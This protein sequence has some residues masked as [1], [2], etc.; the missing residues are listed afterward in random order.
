MS[1][2][3][4]PSFA[5]FLIIAT[6]FLIGRIKIKGISLDISAIIFVALLF[7]H[8]GVIIPS[9]FQDVGLVLFV[10][11]IGLQAGAG[12]F[13]SFRSTGFTLVTVALIMIVIAGGATVFS[14]WAFDIDFDLAVGLLTGALTSTPGLAAAADVTGS[15]MTSIGYGIAY[16]FGVVGVIL[17]VRL[18]PGIIKTPV[19]KAEEEINKQLQEIYPEVKSSNFVVENENILG[20]TIGEL[21]IRSMTGASISRVMSMGR[22]MTPSPDTVFNKGDLVKA[23][24]TQAA[25]EKIRF[26][27]GSSTDLQI[28]LGEEYEVYSILVTNRKVVNKTIGELHLFTSFNA[29]ITRIR[30]SGIDIVP[31]DSSHIR[32][33]DKLLIASNRECMTTVAK[34]F[35]NQEKKLSDTNMF[36]IACG[37]VLGILVGRLEISFSEHTIFRPGLAGGVL[38]VALILGNLGKTGPVIWSMSAAAN[39]LL[40]QIGL[41][42]F[43]AAVGTHAGAHIIETFNSY[44]LQ[45]FL[46]GMI[47]T[48]LPMIITTFIARYFLKINLLSLMGAITGSM[49]STPG[50]AAIDPM[51]SSNAPQIAYATVYPV[52]MVLLVIFVQILSGL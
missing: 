13:R 21:K 35:G 12:F 39:Q 3:L 19:Y 14:V 52:A 34:I 45:L 42:F 4:V 33:G 47:I 18:L 26:L 46:A 32:F 15:P 1:V 31:T 50:L 36:P 10:F 27:I 44:G 29:T 30:R 20:K 28:P 17:F 51:T 7:G 24:G 40:R 41:L 48:I 25:L 49:T 5:L 8:F 11:T 22:A 6:G 43:L 38:I 37:I 23:V 16:P 2:F 9:D